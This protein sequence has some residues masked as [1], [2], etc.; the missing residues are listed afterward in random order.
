MYAVF[1]RNINNTLSVLFSGSYHE[2]RK[3]IKNRLRQGL[4][5]HFL[6]VA[7]DTDRARSM[8]RKRLGI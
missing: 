3:Y 6:H 2:C 5:T 4:P 8:L 1:S 7:R